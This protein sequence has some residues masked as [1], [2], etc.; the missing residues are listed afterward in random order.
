MTEAD[1]E[2]VSGIVSEGYRFIAGPDNLSVQ[3][4]DRLIRERCRPEHMS[5]MRGQS[6][7]SVARHNGIAVGMI[8]VNGSNIE[9][10]FVAPVHHRQGIGSALFRH[11]ERAV[12]AAREAVL[13]VETTG[14]GVPFYKAMGMRAVG[15]L[16][17]AFGP[18]EG[19]E[20]IIMEKELA[21]CDT[22][23]GQHFSR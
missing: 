17:V 23:T 6:E 10:L 2:A 20:N 14:Y 21:D 7:C 4:L 8:A 13:R 19:R 3:Q 9:E 18:L 5:A 11:A 15:R 12:I 22:E 16:R 1:D